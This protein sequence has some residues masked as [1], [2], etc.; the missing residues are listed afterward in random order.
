LG[1]EKLLGV[2]IRLGAKL[3]GGLISRGKKE[4]ARSNRERRKRQR[5]KCKTKGDNGEKKE[6]PMTEKLGK[7]TFSLTKDL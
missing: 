5:G 4:R 7:G 3:W 2:N 1:E 6:R